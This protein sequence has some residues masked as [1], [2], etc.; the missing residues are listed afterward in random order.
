[1]VD[2][3]GGTAGVVTMEDVIETLLG[4]EIVDEADENTDMQQLAR[5][6]WEQRAAR[7]GL[8][9]EA[10]EAEAEAAASERDAAAGSGVPGDEPPGDEQG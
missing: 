7:L 6:R 3:Y 9:P 8:V 1:M 2:G 5:R 10:A 4:L